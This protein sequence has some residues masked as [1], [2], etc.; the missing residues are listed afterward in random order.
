MG[1]AGPQGPMGI[2]G[3]PG[4]PTSG[5]QNA[6]LSIMNDTV[7]QNTVPYFVNATGNRVCQYSLL[8]FWS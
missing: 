6:M 1:P 4:P 7:P 8:I 5:G 2:P 3:P